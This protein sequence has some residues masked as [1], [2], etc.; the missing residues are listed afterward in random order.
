M[1]IVT[2]MMNRTDT[3]MSTLKIN[4]RV[5]YTECGRYLTG[6]RGWIKDIVG[7]NIYVSFGFENDWWVHRET[8]E[9]IS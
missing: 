9:K 3:S 7:E 4:D 6:C 2:P 1:F 8:L 5:R